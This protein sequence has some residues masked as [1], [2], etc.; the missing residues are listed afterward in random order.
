MALEGEFHAPDLDHEFFPDAIW[1]ADI[2]NG[3]FTIDR[4]VF[5]RLIMVGVLLAF[6]LIAMRRPKLIPSGLQNVGELLL[7]FVRIHIAEE[8]LGRKEGRRFLP[9]I[10]TIFFLVLFINAPSII[11]FLNISPNARIAMPL[12]LAIVGYIAFIYA[13]AKKYG[14]F[15]YMKSSV[16]IP[17]LPLPLHFAV[18]PL[19][20]LSTFILR[21][22]TLTVRLMANMLVGHIILVLLF[23]ASNFFFWQMNG[24][25]ALS[26]VTLVAGVAFT[27]FEML[28]IFLQAYIFALLVAVYI[29]LSL[30][31]DEH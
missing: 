23:S 18:V 12:V 6:F 21:P 4:L 2:A 9:V 27:I 14:F 1:F 3:W 10:A 22:A 26:A 25:T 15:K 29:E 5:V 30:H 11:P 8:I 31:A 24:W 17:N 20:F 16:V 13:G 28:V 7:D 19:E